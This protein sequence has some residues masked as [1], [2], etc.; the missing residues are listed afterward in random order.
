M[1]R[2]NVSFAEY[3]LIYGALLQKRRIFLRNLLIIWKKCIQCVERD[4]GWRRLA[5]SLKIYVSFAE[6]RLFYGALLQKRRMIWRSLRIVATPHAIYSR[7]EYSWI[8]RDIHIYIKETIYV[9]TTDVCNIWKDP[10]DF[11]SINLHVSFAKEPQKRDDILQKRLII[12][13]RLLIVVIDGKTDHSWIP[14]DI[15]IYMIK[16][17]YMNIHENY[18]VATISRLLKIIPLFCRI[19]SLL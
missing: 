4:M 15:E 14:W 11:C 9:Y 6:Y 19:S 1:W 5:G 8:T 17:R 10:P 2:Y 16:R 13:R 3:R 12:L 7:R 18:R